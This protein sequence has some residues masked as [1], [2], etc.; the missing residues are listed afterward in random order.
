MIR[1]LTWGVVASAITGALWLMPITSRADGAP[2]AAPA[3]PATNVDVSALIS[4]IDEAHKN[5]DQAGGDAALGAAVD[6]A[7]KAAPDNYDVLWRAARYHCWLSDSAPSG[8]KRKVPEAKACWD[9]G[10][11]AVKINGNGAE[12]LYVA[13]SGVGQY[14]NEIGVV[15]ALTQGLEGTFNGYVDKALKI[16][17]TVENCGPYVLKGRYY[18]ALPWPKRDLGK[19]EEVLRKGIEKCPQKVRLHVF[20]AETLLKDGKAKDAQAELDKA[21]ALGV[22]PIDQPEERRAIKLIDGVQKQVSE[23]L[24]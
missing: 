20:L 17:G 10:D 24:K 8:D 1:S 18:F 11:K 9:L 13:G 22:G 15:K 5:R 21:K 14:S 3:A 7:L 6:E 12:G 2:A 19:S 23:E 4:K 16:N